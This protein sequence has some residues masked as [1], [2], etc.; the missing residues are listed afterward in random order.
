[1][2][3]LAVASIKVYQYAISP[4]MASHCRF[5]P[6]CS[7]YALEAIETHGL[8]RGGWLSLRRLG[9]CH[10]WNPGGYD[11]VPS[12]KTSNSSPMAE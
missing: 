3:K 6:S 11:P 7:C 8:F 12:Q 4:M 5:Y 9:R 2:R 1:M 10:P